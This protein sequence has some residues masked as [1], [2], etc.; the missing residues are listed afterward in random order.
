MRTFQ[1]EEFATPLGPMYL[2]SG[3]GA[4]RALEFGGYEARMERLLSAWGK[5][6]VEPAPAGSS[7]LRRRIDD[8]FAGD[9]A[10]VDALPADAA[11]TDF[12]REVW[13]ALRAIPAGQTWT[14]GQL[15]A[16][17]GRPKAVRAVGLANSQNPVAI[18]QPCHRVIGANGKLTGYAGGL[19]KKE[20]LLRHEGAQAAGADAR[21]LS[22]EA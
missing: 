8:Y 16:H 12:Q 21:Q 19:D 17:I 18:V 7:D 2:V 3:E 6:R 1:V 13:R 20:W 22:F 4:I 9:L 14:Y 15:A 10:A 11:G 5:V